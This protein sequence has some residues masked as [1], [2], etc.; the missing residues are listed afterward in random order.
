MEQADPDLHFKSDPVPLPMARSQ[1]YLASN[2]LDMLCGLLKTPERLTR[3]YYPATPVF[4]IRHKV[5]VRVSDDVS[6]QS[7]DDIRRLGPEGLI[8]TPYGGAFADYLKRQGGLR[9][10]TASKDM[11]LM[12]H[13]LA[14]GYARFLYHSESSLR[15]YIRHE[16]LQDKVR[17]LP[18]VFYEESAYIVFSRQL[19]TAEL[20]RL[21]AVLAQLARQGTLKRLYA[22]YADE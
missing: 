12:L 5:A 1:A 7:F 20:Q 17:L 11:A 18:A 21:E 3:F 10:D 13:W 15:A 22:R 19:P 9:V 4:D 2:R 8:M 14:G 6:V 16:G